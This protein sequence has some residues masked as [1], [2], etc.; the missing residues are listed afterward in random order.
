[1]PLDELPWERWG[2][3]WHRLRLVNGDKLPFIVYRPNPYPDTRECC[4]YGNYAW[5][6][7]D[8]EGVSPL[9]LQ[10]LIYDYLEG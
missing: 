4:A 5:G 7:Y 8:E 3:Y 2:D 1:M 10:C 9:V 6:G